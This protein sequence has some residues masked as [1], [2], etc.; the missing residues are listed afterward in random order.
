VSILRNEPLNAFDFY[1][2]IKKLFSLRTDFDDTGF[3]IEL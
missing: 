2:D 1:E 3:S